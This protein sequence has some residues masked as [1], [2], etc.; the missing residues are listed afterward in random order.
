MRYVGFITRWVKQH[1]QIGDKCT[2]P[3]GIKANVDKE[4]LFAVIQQLFTAEDFIV[5][6]VDGNQFAV[7][8][9]GVKTFAFAIQR[10]TG[11]HFTGVLD[12]G[13][14]FDILAIN[15]PNHALFTNT[16][17]V[18]GVRGII[19]YQLTRLQRAHLFRALT[20]IQ[21]QTAFHFARFG[22]Y[23]RDRA[24]YGVTNNV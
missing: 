9:S 19:S 4:V 24:V 22:I 10:Q 5:G 1:S 18:N 7:S 12:G 3:G 14:Q 21:H 8:V 20:I 13:F 11:T 17:D 15:D 23:R 2:L 16:T 6:G